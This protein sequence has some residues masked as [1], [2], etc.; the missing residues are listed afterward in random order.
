MRGVMF[1]DNLQAQRFELKYLVTEEVALAVR[2]FVASYLVLDENSAGKPNNSYPNHSIYLDS[3]TLTLYW[4][5]I[6]GN[7]NR[8][9]LRLRYYDE[10][11]AAPVFFEIKRRSNDAILKQRG[12]VRRGAVAGLLA[13]QLPAPEH[14]MS[15][16]PRHLVAVQQFCQLLLDLR[17]TPK[18]RVAYLRE[19]WVSPADNSVRVTLDRDVCSVS[20]SDAT[21]PIR[22]EH[23]AMPWHGQVILELKFTGRYPDW[24]RTLTE[25]FGVMQTGVA[26][27]AEGVA[28]GGEQRLSPGFAPSEQEDLVEQFLKR[29]RPIARTSQANE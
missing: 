18:T 13:G 6:N 20:H 9:K 8:Y 27:Y 17:A 24:F 29:R 28:L 23:P 22:I 15:D 12:P 5:V 16:H 11:P 10:N 1:Q 2:D 4:D 25:I 7:K 14:L 21:L 19:A 26:K 3:E